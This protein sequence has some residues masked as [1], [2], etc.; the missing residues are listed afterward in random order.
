MPPKLIP[1]DL[2]FFKIIEC[3]ARAL[4]TDVR[5]SMLLA[6]FNVLDASDTVGEDRAPFRLLSIAAGSADRRA[7]ELHL[8]TTRAT[9]RMIALENIF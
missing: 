2:I 3:D 8:V 6:I 7:V 5:S 1:P 9:S 4:F